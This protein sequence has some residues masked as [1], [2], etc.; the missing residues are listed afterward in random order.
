MGYIQSSCYTCGVRHGLTLAISPKPQEKFRLVIN[1]SVGS[2]RVK[3]IPEGWSCLSA[4]CYQRL[5]LL[6]EVRYIFMHCLLILPLICSYMW[7]LV[8]K[9]HIWCISGFVLKIG[10]YRCAG[11]LSTSQCVALGRQ[12]MSTTHWRWSA[13]H[14]LRRRW[15]PHRNPR[16]NQSRRRR[17]T[18]H[19]L[20]SFMQKPFH[21]LDISSLGNTHWRW[22]CPWLPWTAPSLS[23]WHEPVTATCGESWWRPMLPPLWSC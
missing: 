16:P 21:L 2:Y 15:R 3:L 10:Y 13:Q 20:V 6:Y 18:P 5:S 11:L 7:D 9:T 1:Q 19:L 8:S 12:A 22:R 17:P 14:G 23:R 4:V